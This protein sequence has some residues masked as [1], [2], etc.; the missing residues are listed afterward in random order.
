MYDILIIGAGVAGALIARELGRYNLKTALIDKE[1]DVACG[2]T[3]GNSA[4]IH[5]GFDAACGTLKAKLNVEGCALMPQL[6]AELGVHYK[7]NG[8]LVCA[9]SDE[10]TAQLEILKK[11]GETNGVPKLRIIS[12]EELFGLEPNLSREVKAALYAPTAGIICP[13]F[14]TIAAAECAV[15][16]GCD[17]F[18]DFEAEK[19]TRCGDYFSVETPDQKKL[20][21]KFIINSAGLYSD[22]I[23]A[24]FGE[25]TEDY[26]ITPRRGEYMVFDKLIGNTVSATLFAVPSDKGKGVLVAPTVDGNLI[27]GPN[28]EKT[29]REDISTTADGLA[30]IQHNAVRLVPELNM[31]RV[32]TSFAGLR[33]T[34]KN[35]D[36]NIFISKNALHLIGIESPGLAASP[37]IALYVVNMLKNNGINLTPKSDFN[38]V[39]TGKKAF[40]EMS[41][42]ERYEAVR[43]NNL[44][45]KIICRCETV[46][47]AEIV[48]FINSPC[49]ARNLDAVK[50]RTRAGMGRC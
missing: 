31:R 30:E 48:D 44:Y 2:T 24:L 40:R 1:S 26:K 16:N 21:A 43:K 14:L 35:E 4:I 27:V 47:E 23:A 50:R 9:F 6:A 28:A 22:K 25:D 8:S 13:Y 3:K 17:L 32:I 18:L 15:L 12:G 49:P 38:P 20:E 41:D 37:A 7:N 33:A 34:P 42:D 46:T 10:E 11:R 29:N 36:F 5:A 39:I 45:A 19:I